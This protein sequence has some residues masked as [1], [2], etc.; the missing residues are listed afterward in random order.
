MDLRL[1]GPLEARLDNGPIELGP[2]KQRAVL[3]MLALE[4]ER[5]V[6]V[7]RLVEGL[8]GESPPSSAPK[9]VQLYVSRLRRVLDGN[10]ARIVT[11]G[12]GYELQLSEVAV[13][14]VRFELL[15]DTRPRE[16]LA[17]WRGAPLADLADE[18]F[19]AVEIRRLEELRLR[20]TELA[21][22]A[23]LA[24]GRH[25][26][27]IGELDALVVQE[28]L[29]ERLRAQRML[30]LYRSGRQADA[31]EA[32]RDARAALVE[33]GIEPGE[34]LHALHHAILE[35][36][37]RIAAPPAAATGISEREDGE[38]PAAPGRGRRRP[39]SRSGLLIVAGALA[40]V[41]AGV[42]A[43]WP[44]REAQVAAVRSNAVAEID[45]GD[46]SLGGQAV[47][48]GPPSAIAVAPGAIWVAGD[49]DGTVSRIDP[50]THTVR[51]TVEVGTARARWPPTAAASGSPTATT[52]C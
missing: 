13:D 21:I 36:D 47:L 12:R 17:L 49:R 45:P 50:E 22:D 28:P 37:P 4:V 35:H 9:M 42:A 30:A 51:Q 43:F 24:A 33:L 8:W 26:E 15:L 20:A 11:R 29:R 19:A 2:R 3:A 1:L 23:D 14:A 6:S 38:A 34:E 16:A 7:D 5:T 48:D 39:L 41:G 25:A 46:G 10:G 44:D 32:Y 52:A 40:A 31:L 18:P 27:V